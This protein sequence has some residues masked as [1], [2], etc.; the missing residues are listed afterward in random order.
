MALGLVT[1]L[2][3]FEYSTKCSKTSF[4]FD[5]FFRIAKRSIAAS[6]FVSSLRLFLLF[7]TH[8]TDS[9]M[10]GLALARA[11]QKSGV[12]TRGVAFQAAIIASA[13]K[14]VHKTLSSKPAFLDNDS[15]SS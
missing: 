13:S 8:N 12:Q 7:Q 9:K 10:S 5:S 4:D 3:T 1:L 15:S 11:A 14:K 6:S 2:C